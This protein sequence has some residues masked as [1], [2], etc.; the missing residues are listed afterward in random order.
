MIEKKIGAELCSQIEYLIFIKARQTIN[1]LLSAEMINTCDRPLRNSSGWSIN[2]S[3]SLAVASGK[4]SLAKYWHRQRGIIRERQKNTAKWNHRPKE[5][6]I[7]HGHTNKISK[8]Q[9]QQND[10]RHHNH[11]Y[12]EK[13]KLWLWRTAEMRAMPLCEQT[14]CRLM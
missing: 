6:K 2:N 8:M 14:E 4:S 13:I 9:K 5:I 7:W 12:N 1:T 10:N 11:S 3:M